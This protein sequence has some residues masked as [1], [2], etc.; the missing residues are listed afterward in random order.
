[1]DGFYQTLISICFTL[2]GLWW[3]VVQF[4]HDEWMN[5]PDHRRMAYAVYLS[6]L[7]PGMMSMGS[8][9]SGDVRFIWQAVFVVSAI[10]GGATT[11]FMFQSVKKGAAHGWLFQGGRWVVIALYALVALFAIDPGLAAPLKP[12]QVEGLLLSGLIFLGVNFAWTL[13]AHPKESA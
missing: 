4:R 7:V 5:D 11:F 12:L 9:V 6:F 1:M 8:L 2:M 13:M 10:L 3:A